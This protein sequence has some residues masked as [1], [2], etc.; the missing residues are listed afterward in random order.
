[1]TIQSAVINAVTKSYIDLV[2]LLLPLN[3]LYIT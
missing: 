1:L 2:N 3:K